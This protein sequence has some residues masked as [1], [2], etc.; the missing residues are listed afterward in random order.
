MYTYDNF[1]FKPTT[2]NNNSFQM[3]HLMLHYLCYPS[4]KFLYLF[5]EVLVFILHFY[6]RISFCLTNSGQR[7]TSL[8][9]LIRL[10]L[11]CDNRIHHRNDTKTNTKYNDSLFTPIIFAAIPTQCSSFVFKVS[12]KSIMTATSAFV[13]VSNFCSR[14]NSTLMIGFTIYL[15]SLH[16]YLNFI[17]LPLLYILHSHISRILH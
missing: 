9:G 4:L 13:T 11:F 14:N 6:S 16:F 12:I 5:L 8:F 10:I 2:L 17:N 7:Q 3:I 1:H 15:H